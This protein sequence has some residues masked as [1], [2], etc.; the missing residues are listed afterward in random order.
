MSCPL[1][2]SFDG[3][4]WSDWIITSLWV[5]RYPMMIRALSLLCS[6]VS[7]VSS[8]S[9]SVTLSR[10]PYLAVTNLAALLC[11]IS[12]LYLSSPGWGLHTVDA[13]S[14]VG[15]TSALYAFSLVV[16]DATSPA[17]AFEEFNLI[18][19][20]ICVTAYNVLVQCSVENIKS[21]FLSLI[22]TSGIYMETMIGKQ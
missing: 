13:Y 20:F 22:D 5:I 3:L 16:R 9:I 17:I 6:N 21:K 1:L 8:S 11:I 19:L 15:C 10:W 4:S 14:S 7:H 18:I 12:M 2:V